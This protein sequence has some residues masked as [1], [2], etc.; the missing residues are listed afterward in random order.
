MVVII[1]LLTRCAT[2]GQ[3]ERRRKYWW[4]AAAISPQIGELDTILSIVGNRRMVRL[5]NRL[6]THEQMKW[7]GAGLGGSRQVEG[8]GRRAGIIMFMS[9][10]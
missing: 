4:L 2:N 3:S 6:G 7:N 5:N 9:A 10:S 1:D 8:H